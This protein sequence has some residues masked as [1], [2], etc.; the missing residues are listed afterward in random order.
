MRVIQIK[1]RLDDRYYM[2]NE[3]GQIFYNGFR[4]SN[5]WLFLG[6]SRHH[7]HNHITDPFSPAMFDNPQSMIGGYVWAEDHGTTC[8]WAGQKIYNAWVVEI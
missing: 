3:K 8:T 5:K 7:W 6:L 4:P 1:R 2:I